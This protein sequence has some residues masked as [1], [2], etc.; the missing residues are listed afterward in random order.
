MAD[1]FADI[2]QQHAEAVADGKACPH[3][4]SV[5]GWLIVEIQRL[6]DRLAYAA[7]RESCEDRG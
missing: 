3:C 7:L 4:A 5:K 1:P 2:A 6:R